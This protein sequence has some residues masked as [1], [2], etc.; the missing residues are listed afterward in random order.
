M[1]ENNCK[2]RQLFL[3]GGNFLPVIAEDYCAIP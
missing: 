2:I 1:K 3:G